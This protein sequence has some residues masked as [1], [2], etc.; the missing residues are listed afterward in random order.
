[1]LEKKSGSNY[2]FNKEAIAKICRIANSKSPPWNFV[3]SRSES[4]FVDISKI[5][6]WTLLV[7]FVN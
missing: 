3:K 5:V 6:C 1:M 4:F 7:L 2:F